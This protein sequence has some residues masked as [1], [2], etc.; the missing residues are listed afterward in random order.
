M[1]TVSGQAKKT[2]TMIKKWLQDIFDQKESTEIKEWRT[3]NSL[4]INFYNGDHIKEIV[5]NGNARIGYEYDS[6]FTNEIKN[7]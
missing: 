6:L 5:L 7:V 3:D 4:N 1:L 2:D